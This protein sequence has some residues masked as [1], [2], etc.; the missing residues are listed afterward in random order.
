[1][2]V[3][4][5]GDAMGMLEGDG[6]VDVGRTPAGFGLQ[7]AVGRPSGRPS[8][9]SDDPLFWSDIEVQDTPQ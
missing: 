9:P 2:L 1:L 8:A 6:I 3:L 7:P 5:L 4:D